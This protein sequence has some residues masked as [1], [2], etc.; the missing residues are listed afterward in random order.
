MSRNGASQGFEIF[1]WSRH[2]ETGLEDIDDQHRVLVNILNRLAWHFASGSPEADSTH[3]LDEL[4][5][6]ASYHFQ[7]EEGVWSRALGQSAMC[8]N[9]HEAHELFF[10]RIQVLRQSEAPEEEVLADLFDYL[11][12]WLA[13]NI[14]ESDR[15]MALT[16]KAVEAGAPLPQ[17][18][19]QVDTELSG[20]MS[21][22]VTALLEIYGKLSASAIQLMHEKLARQRA[23]SEVAHLQ[24]ER[25]HHA[26]E[27]QAQDHQNQMAFLAYSDPLTGLL[28]RNGIIRAVREFLE[29]GSLEDNSAALVSIDLDNF[30]EIN[31]R[32]GEETADRV[33]GLLARRWQD[34]LPPNAALARIGGDEFALLMT[35]ARQVE[36]R[37]RALQLTCL[38]PFELG[39]ASAATSFTAGIVCF[40]SREAGIA[41][42]DADILLRQADH[43]LFRAKQEMKGSWLFLDVEERERR[44]SR[45]RLL[46]DIRAGLDQKQFRL[47]YQPKV[48]LRSGTVQYVEA[49]IRWQ[50]PDRG[51][52]SPANFLPA[53]EHHPLIVELGEWAL[54]EALFQMNAW[55]GEGVTLGI[56][57]NIAPIHLL[58]PTFV[59]RLQSILDRFPGQA[60]GRLDLEIVETAALG[61]LEKAVR[62]IHDCQRLGVTFSLDDFGTGYSSLSY[63]KQLPV[64]TLKIDREFVSGADNKGENHLIL[65]GI[66]GL[67]RVFGRE[68]VAEGVETVEQGE[69][70]LELGCEWAQGYLISPPVAPD[71]LIQWLAHWKPFPEWT[72]SDGT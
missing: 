24:R 29:N 65:K 21:I 23:E 72:R 42:K 26:L 58:S 20:P 68:L 67:A 9:H 35:D 54:E 52:L 31:A 45:Q 39:D 27:T 36:S 32:F 46:S 70:L 30:H 8:R 64:Q 49:L 66:V 71:K 47:F 57:V 12:R 6:Y 48:N 40:P 7:Y 60:P 44:M 55:D 5:G 51:L 59:A 19:D 3:L 34:A 22:M 15:R 33:L 4:L 43:T 53:I 69:L 13:F 1:P 38:Q 63:L 10:A 28:N 16:V 62:V 50:H 11:T 2:F 41:S 17:A 61:E 56:S 37:L 14:L 25:L 18:L